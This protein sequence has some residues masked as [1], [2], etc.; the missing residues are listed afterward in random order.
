MVRKGNLAVFEGS[1]I[2]CLGLSDDQKIVRCQELVYTLPELNYK[3][4]KYLI[5]FIAK[6][7][8]FNRYS[9]YL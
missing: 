4:L 3:I 8:T 5:E 2:S 1:N 9:S 6:V 7:N